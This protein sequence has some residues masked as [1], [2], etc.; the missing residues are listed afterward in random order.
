[1]TIRPDDRPQSIKAWLEL[2]EK[3]EDASAPEPA[4][5]N[6][7][8]ATVIAS[9][10][11]LPEIVPVA[12]ATPGFA[13][14]EEVET[15]V[16]EDPSEV[17][18][19]LAGQDTNATR[20]GELVKDEAELVAVVEQ[21]GAGQAE[22]PPADEPPADEPPAAEAAGAPEPEPVQRPRQ[23]CLLPRLRPQRSL[24]ESRSRG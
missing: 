18:F 9:F 11:D 13:L 8:D 21:Q 2:F 22:E 16:P 15:S 14:P 10:V 5:D 3:P 20:K 12:P 23:P 24:P 1:M 17:R 19:K 6:G 7:D 4:I